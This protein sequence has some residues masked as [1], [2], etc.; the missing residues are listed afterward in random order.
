MLASTLAIEKK[1]VLL[2]SD[3]PDTI[4]T[5]RGI[6]NYL[7]PAIVSP[8]GLTAWVPSKQDNVKRG[9]LREGTQ[10]THDQTI[11]SIAS[12]I[13]LTS[14]SPA[15]TD[16]STNRVDFDNAG[17]A[18]NA[19][20]EP[21]GIYMFT[22]LEGSREVGV[23]D[24]W[25]KKEIR[26][27]SAGR[28]PQG[29]AVS[30]DG[31][32]VYVQNFMDRTVTIHDVG[33]VIDGR[34]TVPTLTATLNC[35]TTERLTATVLLGKKHFYDAADTRIAFQQYISCAS[36]H[37]DGGQDGRVWD[38]TGFAEGLRNTI[39]LRGHGGVAQGP[40]H[41]SGNFDEIQDFENQIHT[42]PLGTG[43]ITTGSPNPPLGSP[44]GG[45]SADLDALASYVTSLS[46]NDASPYR[47]AD[48]T[49]TASG[50][51]GRQVFASN[52][53]AACHSGSQF[54]DSAVN[55]LHDVGTIKP[56]SGTR[57]GAALTGLDTPSLRGVW[58]NGPYLHD[59]SAA[60]LAAAIAAHTTVPRPSLGTQ[61]MTDLVS[62]LL[63][64]DDNETNPNR[65]P[66][67]HHARHAEHR[68][69]SRCFAANHRHRSR[70]QCT[71]LLGHRLAFGHECQ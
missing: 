26:R 9:M 21:K 29:I 50:I 41:W 30:P 40:V 47:N 2:H 71:H 27:F 63:Q 13:A 10:L 6:P 59:G 33:A 64:I 11:R 44:N 20:F 45:R 19:A 12:R 53:C 70:K 37:N 55:V 18:V 62:F 4:T 49:T 1:T 60:T 7:G 25:G 17:I 23:V 52:N 32:T 24:V 8:D 51:A 58:D 14:G 34:D 22:A 69:R 16:D 48:N 54:T 28:A 3:R 15:L 67:R 68:A 46:S 66:H 38:F 65:A 57:L 42:L 5:G 35:I 43:L 61:A 36:C 39:A 56:A 31:R